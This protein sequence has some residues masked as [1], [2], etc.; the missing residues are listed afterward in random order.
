MGAEQAALNLARRYE[1]SALSSQVQAAPDTAP[2]SRSSRGV[3]GE[4]EGTGCITAGLPEQGQRLQR[5]MK[6]RGHP[7][8]Q[9]RRG[10]TVLSPGAQSWGHGTGQ[11]RLGATEHCAEEREKLTHRHSAGPSRAG[12]LLRRGMWI[13]SLQGT[14]PDS[15]YRGAAA[16]VGLPLHPAPSATPGQLLCSYLGEAEDTVSVNLVQFEQQVPGAQYQRGRGASSTLG[17]Q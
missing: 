2:P 14:P 7:Q 3:Q 12:K 8:E 5:R 17:V 1:F 10:G 9:R 15:S 6:D 13:V 4:T 11:A 16:V